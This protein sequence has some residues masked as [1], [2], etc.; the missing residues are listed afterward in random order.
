MTMTQPLYIILNVFLS[1]R[2]LSELRQI[3]LSSI[4]LLLSSD[5]CDCGLYTDVDMLITSRSTHRYSCDSDAV[6]VT[7]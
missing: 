3:C 7:L 4:H 5:S 2:V 1:E 6:T